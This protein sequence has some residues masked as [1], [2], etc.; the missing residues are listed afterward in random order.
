MFRG[1]TRLMT[2]YGG[3]E[4]GGTKFVCAT[5]GEDGKLL[6]RIEFPATTPAETIA[7]AL[8][9][10]RTQPHALHSIGIGS[11]GPVD[12]DPLSPKFGYITSTP[13]NGW[14]D[15]D[16][17]GAVRRADRKSTRLNSSHL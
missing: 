10:F 14:L 7:R 17:L 16:L 4:C 1:I 12:L 13:K 9:F 8:E 11:F 15:T 5:G 3:M 2:V 6:A